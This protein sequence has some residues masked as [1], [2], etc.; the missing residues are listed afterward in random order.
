[1]NYL[2]KNPELESFLH[3]VYKTSKL[4]N[5]RTESIEA[6]QDYVNNFPEGADPKAYIAS[7]PDSANNYKGRIGVG[8]FKMLPK[9][10]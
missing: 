5:K 2:V 1:M 8:K 6:H 3:N 9:Q 4:S 10:R 7:V